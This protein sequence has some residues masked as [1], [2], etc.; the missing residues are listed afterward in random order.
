VRIDKDKEVIHMIDPTV[1]FLAG[2]SIGQ[3]LS[4]LLVAGGIRVGEARA[5]KEAMKDLT[6]PQK[7][8]RISNRK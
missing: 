6:A 4:L 2:L 1:A 5:L 3:A 8:R 7:K